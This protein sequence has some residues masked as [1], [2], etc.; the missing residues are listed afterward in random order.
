MFGFDRHGFGKSEGK[1]G[2]IG[3]DAV[4]ESLIFIDKVVEAKSLKDA[5]KY[6]FSISMGSI[7]TARMI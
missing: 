7:M 3:P 6:I 1:R 5:K 4:K 2:D